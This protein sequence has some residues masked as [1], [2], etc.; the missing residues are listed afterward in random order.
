MAS[1]HTPHKKPLRINIWKVL[2]VILWIVAAD[3]L[4]V[5]LTFPAFDIAGPAILLVAAIIGAVYAWRR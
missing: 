4:Y 5:V 1:L 3:L 2:S